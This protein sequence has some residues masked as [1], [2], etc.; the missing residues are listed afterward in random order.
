MKTKMSITEYS[1]TNSQ[2]E[3]LNQIMK[4]YL[5][6]YVNYQQDNWIELLSAAQFTYN[7]STQTLTE[8]SLFQTE[9]DKNMQINDKT[10]KLKDNNDTAIQ[11]DKKIQQIYKQLKKNLQFVHKKM[12]IYYNL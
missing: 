3:Q 9:Y 6:C 11:Q 4:Q 5:K 1:Q 12:K 7:N 10:V 8:I 2:I